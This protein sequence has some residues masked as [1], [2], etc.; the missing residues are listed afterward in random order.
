MA[1]WLVLSRAA[2]CLLL[3]GTNIPAFGW[4]VVHMRSLHARRLKR[5]ISKARL[6]ETGKVHQQPQASELMHLS[7]RHE[8]RGRHRSDS[9]M[10]G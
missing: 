8:G 10:E 7:T 3:S 6:P 4:I 1:N 2:E 5:G 9:R